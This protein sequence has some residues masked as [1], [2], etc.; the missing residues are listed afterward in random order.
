MLLEYNFITKV[1]EE[2]EAALSCDGLTEQVARSHDMLGTDLTSDALH[3]T[4][5]HSSV[6]RW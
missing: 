6:C 3:E 4:T 5:H 1:F 2:N